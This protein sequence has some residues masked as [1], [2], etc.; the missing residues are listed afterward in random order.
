[1]GEGTLL[2]EVAKQVGPLRRLVRRLKVFKEYLL[3]AVFFQR[4]FMDAEQGEKSVEYEILLLVHSLEKGLARGSG[5][6]FGRSKATRLEELLRIAPDPSVGAVSPVALSMGRSVLE[7]WAV[8]QRRRGVML[9]EV[10]D[11]HLRDLVTSSDAL[12][13]REAGV[14][15]RVSIDRDVLQNAPYQV[16]VESRHTAR[17]YSGEP[18][19]R[20]VVLSCVEL[21][22]RSP[23][24]CNRQM[25]RFRVIE[26]PD[27]KRRLFDMLHGTGG[28]D[29]EE[30]TFGVVSFE[31][32]GLSFAGERNQGYLNVGLFALGLVYAFHSRGIGSCLVQFGNT[33]SEENELREW[34]HLGPSERVGVCIAFGYY[35]PSEMFP[36]SCRRDSAE[37]VSW[38]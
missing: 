28:V 9:P 24:A 12:G 4:H 15:E 11:L 13:L 22:L 18:V 8:E 31:V 3:D 36:N 29:F 21:A 5:R 37:V 23:S 35:A 25:V 26:D 30:A 16:L 20:E 10:E 33:V 19:S 2:K 1:M 7:K 27:L 17:R 32:A 6:P 14:Q 38:V 34:L